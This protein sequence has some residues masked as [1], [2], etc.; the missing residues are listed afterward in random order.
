[1]DHTANRLALAEAAIE[2]A[3]A[4]QPDSGQTHLALVDHF[5]CGYLDFS[6]ASQ[7]LAL[8]RS[9]LPNEPRVFELAG[10]INRRQGRWNEC[11]DDL[12]R[13]LELDPHNFAILQ[14]LAL[15]YHYL[16]RFAEEAAIQNRALQLLPKDIGARLQQAAIELKWH[17]NTQPLHSEI[18]AILG[19]D[20]SATAE[21]A[22]VWIF[23]ALTE[24]DYRTAKLAVAA[25]P[26]DGTHNAGFSFPRAWSEAT[27]ARAAGD[28]QVAQV[29]FNM[30]RIEVEKAVRE[31]PNYGEPLSVLAM[32]DAGLG[33][34]Q[35]AIAEGHRAVEL[36]PLAKDAIN[37]SLAIEH[38]ALVYAWTGDKEQACKYLALATK[39][40]G[41]VGYGHLCLHP[42]WDL[43]RGDAEFER[44]VALLAPK[45]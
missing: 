14:N 17:A 31:Q 27:V 33:R 13:A 42:E 36:L 4:L 8:A 29:A 16:R 19:E 37:G 7:E 28:S 35:E 25:L 3:Q 20:P 30:A 12:N 15:T 26:A 18:Q 10:Y 38:L 39:L 9:T 22:D 23:L 44:I 41:D 11:I 34:K 5:Y 45:Q 24:R 43:V 32:I 6:R 2:K 21:V 40:P 1:M